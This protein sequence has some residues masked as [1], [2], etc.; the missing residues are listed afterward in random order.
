MV[1]ILE[2]LKG[3]ELCDFRDSVFDEVIEIF[4]KDKNVIVLTNDMVPEA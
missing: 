1:E 4:K 2:K 3:Q